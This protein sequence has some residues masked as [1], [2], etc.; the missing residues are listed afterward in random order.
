MKEKFKNLSIYQKLTVIVA[1]TTVFAMILSTIA[2][3]FWQEVTLTQ[4]AVKEL[5]TTA[6]ILGSNG[7]AAL[8]FKV[9]LDAEKI[10]SSLKAKN[11]IV[12]ARFYNDKK[13]KFAEYLRDNSANSITEFPLIEGHTFTFRRIILVKHIYHDNDF[14]GI[15]QIISDLENLYRHLIE[16]IITAIFIIFICS[17]LA[18]WLSFKFLREISNPISNL[19]NTAKEV[20]QG[21]DYSKRAQIF[22]D[23]DLGKLTEGFNNMLHQIELRNE[24][25]QDA[26]KELEKRLSEQKK[27][28]IKIEKGLQEKEL[29]LK[30]LKHRTKNNLQIIANLIK[31]QINKIDDEKY[32]RIF[33]EN[34]NRIYS[35][36]IIEDKIFRSDDLTEI[37]ADD[38]FKVIGKQIF[39]LGS[40]DFNSIKL[41]IETNGLM[42]DIEKSINCGLIVN[43]LITNAIKYAFPEQKNG[44]I[45]IGLKKISKTKYE[46]LYQDNGVGFPEGFKIK[47]SD[48]MG[49]N[50][51]TLLAEYNL[52]GTFEM[53]PHQGAKFRITF[54]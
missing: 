11:H 36:S 28:E 31:M 49:L 25:L 52:D 20:T 15:I 40:S 35:I 46:L 23:D 9:P 38:Y 1:L 33:Q 6:E 22:A 7:S 44:E 54:E 18:I 12:E 42:I 27:A 5:E 32:S 19:L 16:T 37:D 14:I 13:E 17:F 4:F 50:L 26:H 24:E 45:F 53:E 41:N 48:S 51:V 8:R 2:I 21:R 34:Y 39:E 43:E 29:L 47:D 30:E 3:L 10:L